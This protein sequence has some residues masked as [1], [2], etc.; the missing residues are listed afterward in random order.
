MSSGTRSSRSS[1]KRWGADVSELPGESAVRDAIQHVAE[2]IG[3]DGRRR[4][5]I[6]DFTELVAQAALED[7][8][9]EGIHYRIVDSQ[10][11]GGKVLAFHMPSTFTAVKQFLKQFNLENEYSL[12]GKTDFLDNYSDKAGDESA[13]PLA[14]NQKVRGL[15]NGSKAVYIDVEKASETLGEEFELGAFTDVDDQED[16]DDEAETDDGTVALADI[17][18]A[19]SGPGSVSVRVTVSDTL[20]PK[21]WLQAEGTVEDDSATLD[22]QARGDSSPLPANAEGNEYVVHDVRLTSGEYG[23]PV[24]EFRPD[25]EFV[26]VSATPADQQSVTEPVADGGGSGDDVAADAWEVPKDADGKEANARRAVAALLAA[27]RDTLSRKELRK[28]MVSKYPSQ[29]LQPDAM[30]YAIDA[31]VSEY[32]WLVK[33][34]DQGLR[35]S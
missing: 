23:E 2:N 8:L 28:E 33:N 20:E 32:G 12:L 24:L 17:E 9:E 11:Y 5:H 14:T 34:E 3:P 1:P 22:F 27:D 16:A 29:G 7:H 35:P 15:E 6:D 26:S 4:Q 21:P 13:Y 30:N 19:Y 18:E 10:K 25:T 31:A